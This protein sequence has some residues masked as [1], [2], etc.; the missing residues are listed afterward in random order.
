MGASVAPGANGAASVVCA[1]RPETYQRVMP[2]SADGRTGGKYCASG[3]GLR[4]AIEPGAGERELGAERLQRDARALLHVGGLR[5]HA[6]HRLPRQ[7]ERHH[8]AAEGDH[9]RHRDQQL[10][11]AEPAGAASHD[12]DPSQI[13]TIWTSLTAGPRPATLTRTTIAIAPPA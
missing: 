6:R 12:T 13:V 5:L 7:D 3:P 8:R 10:D 1:S 4:A 11:E 2:P 9:H